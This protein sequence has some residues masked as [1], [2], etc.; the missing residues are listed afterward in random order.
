M[1]IASRIP[2]ELLL[3]IFSVVSDSPSR[4]HKQYLERNRN[5]KSFALVHRSWWLPARE[6]LQKEVYLQKSIIKGSADE[7]DLKRMPGL[8]VDSE[9]R[10]TKYLTI[11]GYLNNVTSGTGF[12][13]WGQLR[14]LKLLTS[15]RK[16]GITKMSDLARFP[17]ESCSFLSSVGTLTVPSDC[18]R[19]ARP[20]PERRLSQ[21]TVFRTIR[22]RPSIPA[23]SSH[24]FR[25]G[26]HFWSRT[27]TGRSCCCPG[28]RSRSTPSDHS[29]ALLTVQHAKSEALGV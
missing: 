18:C 19:P 12:R 8:L 23:P 5:L 27:G 21:H 13:L 9:T 16:Y 1:S 4:N 10:G 2:P 6:V 15:S 14:Y 20:A 26:R 24:H 7:D 11:G 17:R 3:D 28:K 25:L 22:R 29:Q